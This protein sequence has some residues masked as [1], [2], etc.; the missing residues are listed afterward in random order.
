MSSVRVGVIGAG[1]MGILHSCLYNKLRQS[2]LVAICDNTPIN[3]RLLKSILPKV[4][5]YEDYNQMLE[6]SELDLVVITTPVFLHNRMAKKALEKGSAVFVEKPL[7]LSADESQELVRLSKNSTTYVGYC[8][9]FM[10]TY[11]TAKNILDSG[12]Y[13]AIKSFSSHMFI[14]Q[15]GE[16]RT[17][18]QYDAKKSGGGVVMDLGSHAIDIVNYLVGNVKEVSATTECDLNVTVEDRA[19]IE[20]RM[21]SNIGGTMEISW[22]QNGY[23]LPELLLDIETEKG[24][25][26]V[27]EKNLEILRNKGSPTEGFEKIY[28]QALEKG[29]QINIGGQEF[30][31]EDEHV[32]DAVSKGTDTICN[33][34]EAAKTNYIIEAA[35]KS[36]RDGGHWIS[37]RCDP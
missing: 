22:A 3:L 14:T 27:C 13:G 20:F 12:Q 25:I 30:T 8:R 16:K 1:K 35:Y 5:L 36:M 31:R 11:N 9:R 2:E 33:F 34:R 18:W 15:V 7:A 32:I 26:R 19:N 23:R 24:R 28:K 4:H 6:S 17:G 21:E 37:P 29:V 10:S